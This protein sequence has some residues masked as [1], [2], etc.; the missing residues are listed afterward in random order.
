MGGFV[1]LERLFARRRLGIKPGLDSVQRLLEVLDHPEARLA[2][3]HV[4]GTN[5]KGSVCAM[6]ASILAAAGCRTGCFTSPHLVRFNERFR[7]DGEMVDDATLA[8]LM[9]RVEQA[10]E[11]VEQSGAPPVTFFECAAVMAFEHFRMRGVSLAVLETGMGGRLDA[12]N[13]VTPAVAVITRIAMDHAAYLGD[14]IAT[15]AGEKGGI[16]KPGRPV[17]IGA[18]PD[19]ARN[20]LVQIAHRC[21][22]PLRDASA[23]VGI[24]LVDCGLD[25]MRVKIETASTSLSRVHVPLV[26]EHQLENIALAVA[27][28]EVLR[29]DV[30]LPVAD[31]A[32]RD[33]LRSV[34]WS[35][36]LQVLDKAPPLLVDGAHNPDAARALA[37][38]LRRLLGKRPIGMILGMCEDKHI[39]ATLRELGVLK[40]R[41]WTVALENARG[42]P[43]DELCGL[44][45]S[46]G[47]HAV[48]IEA[49]PAAVTEA[50]EWA[51]QEGGAVC[52]A[53]SL[54]LVGE[55]LAAREAGTI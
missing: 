45:R 30:Q 49:L 1:Q 40:P 39:R 47:L 34:H 16:I 41:L 13:V 26:G 23:S 5:G 3:V 4:A 17:V 37:R 15:I 38:S 6:L 9:D 53:G 25:G 7:V 48:P 54:F 52:V 21:G 36:R 31:E 10:A 50:M 14:D 22:A 29:D 24:D 20:A 28:C 55:V 2:A 27:V 46:A 18:M 8:T 35:G 43:A 12:T 11:T 51:R 33:G 32:V 19:E 42:L 44:A